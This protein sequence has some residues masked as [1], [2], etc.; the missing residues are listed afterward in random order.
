M[1]VLTR[2]I[3]ERLVIAGDVEV[4]VLEVA[5]S[6]VRLGITA[7]DSIGVQR[8]ELC[9]TRPEIDASPHPENRDGESSRGQP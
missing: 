1:L 6:R 3:G 9:G 7:P 4:A 5:G 8:A 2:R